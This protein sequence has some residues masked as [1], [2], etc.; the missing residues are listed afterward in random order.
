MKRSVVFA[1]LCAAI[2]LLGGV[3]WAAGTATSAQDIHWKE[4]P[5]WG[6]WSFHVGMLFFNDEQFKNVYGDK[7]LA[8]YNMNASW[9][10][11]DDF[12]LLGSLG[13][14]YAEGH[15]I[16]PD[17]GS[18][19]SERYQLHFAPAALGLAYRFNFVLDQPV[20]PYLGAAGQ[21]AYWY[22]GKMDSGTKWR[23]YN[24]G[25]CGFG[26]VM[27][28]LDNIEKRASGLLE[29]EWGINNSYLFYE[30]RYSWLNNFDQEDIIDLSSNLHSIGVML[31]F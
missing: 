29:A 22:E 7:G 30:Y 3:A 25:A 10:M 16:S 15:G 18:K 24:Y 20:V 2:C 5:L 19:T 23:S 8:F 11:I 6:T 17:D 31:E 13:Y 21:F 28:L 12:E 27:F 4:S 1:G 26:G 9:K 14:A